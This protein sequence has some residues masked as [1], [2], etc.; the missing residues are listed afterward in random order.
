M[1]L[2]LGRYACSVVETSHCEIKLTRLKKAMRV[3]PAPPAAVLF[4]FDK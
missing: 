1:I 2:H 4:S 3:E